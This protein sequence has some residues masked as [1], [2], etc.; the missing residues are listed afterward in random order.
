LAQP[1][2]PLPPSLLAAAKSSS[3]VK[4]VAA[5]KY[6]LSPA[7]PAG[8]GGASNAVV[9]TAEPARLREVSAKCLKES[10][11]T[12]V[13]NLFGGG[14]PIWETLYKD[15]VERHGYVKAGVEEFTVKGEFE[16]SMPCRPDQTCVR[17]P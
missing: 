5:F 10:N 6:V 3:G 17:R 11:D 15:C 7:A 4:I 14:K 8:A 2:P 13:P 12:Y 16:P 9:A 1:F